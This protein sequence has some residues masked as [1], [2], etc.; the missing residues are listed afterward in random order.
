M[1]N[2]S[3]SKMRE[4]FSFSNKIKCLEEFFFQDRKYRS[5]AVFICHLKFLRSF[6]RKSSRKLIYSSTE[7]QSFAKQSI[8]LRDCLL[9]WIRQVVAEFSR[10]VMNWS[11]NINTRMNQ[12]HFKEFPL[13]SIECG[14]QELKRFFRHPSI[15]RGCFKILLL[16]KSWKLI[17]SL[18]ITS[19]GRERL[20]QNI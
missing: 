11:E 18:T 15:P 14:S 2:L 10:V 4:T 20:K 19:A 1:E 5:W 17:L 16:D 7:S 8:S 3:L 6:N 13:N 12:K 9:F